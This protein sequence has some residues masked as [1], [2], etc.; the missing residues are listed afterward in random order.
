[1]GERENKIEQNEK[2][3]QFEQVW[4][5]WGLKVNLFYLQDKGSRPSIY[6]LLNSANR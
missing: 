5:F 6:S 2:A 1:M 3:L 4:C